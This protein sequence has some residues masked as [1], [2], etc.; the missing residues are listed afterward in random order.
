MDVIL[1]ILLDLCLMVLL[2]GGRFVIIDFNDLYRRI[3]N[4]NNCLKK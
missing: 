3:L 1:V 4:R 2:D